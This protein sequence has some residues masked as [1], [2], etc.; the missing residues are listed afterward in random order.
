MKVRFRPKGQIVMKWA[1]PPL[2]TFSSFLSVY[3]PP[4]FRDSTRKPEM[5]FSASRMKI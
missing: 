3:N 1:F 2:L 4:P 5:T